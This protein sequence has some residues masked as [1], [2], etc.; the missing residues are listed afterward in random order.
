[1]VQDTDDDNLWFLDG[2]QR[3]STIISYLSGE[4]ALSKKTPPV[5]EH[6]IKGAKFADLQEDMQD[7]ILSETL[8]LIK[9]KHM[10]EEEVDNLFVRWNSGSSL[11]KIELTR[12]MHSDLIEQI[13]YISELEFFAED[14]ALTGKARNRFVDQEIILQIAMLLDEGKDNIK[15]FGSA[16]I[17]DYVLRLKETGQVLSDD[18]VKKF[19]L[20][21]HYLN[22]S[23]AEFDY[24]ERTKALKKIHVPMI[25][26]TAQKAMELKVKPNIFGNFIRDFLITNY[27][28]ESDYGQSCQAGSSKKDNVQVRLYEMGMEFE[29]Y[30]KELEDTAKETVKNKE[31]KGATT[32]E[33]KAE[34]VKA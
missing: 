30:L 3:L 5:F 15:G 9:L 8:T 25:F 17:S 28:V 31:V 19:E 10:T 13:N 27:S 11:S 26:F 16:Q 21:S 12:A 20:V 1:M 23:V 6:E 33:G 32:T 22:M 29:E 14:I 24:S 34:V 18:L 7:E 2:K 4:F